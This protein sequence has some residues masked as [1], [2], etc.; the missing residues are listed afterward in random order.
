MRRDGLQ[1]ASSPKGKLE[2]G[3]CAKHRGGTR[4]RITPNSAATGTREQPG[5]VPRH[6]PTQPLASLV[7][8]SKAPHLGARDGRT[9]AEGQDVADRGLLA[10]HRRHQRRDLGARG[11]SGGGGLANTLALRSKKASQ[12][13]PGKRAAKMP[14]TLGRTSSAL[15]PN[16]G[17]EAQSN[18]GLQA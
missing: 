2:A 16:L 3:G 6:L 18:V 4:R 14:V 1:K 17:I 7:H 10:A 9:A 13:A 8:A 11:R 5:K 15:N 12:V